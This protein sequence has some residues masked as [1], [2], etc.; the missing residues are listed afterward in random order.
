MYHMHNSTL[1]S[2]LYHLSGSPAAIADATG[3]LQF[4]CPGHAML[5]LIRPRLTK[6]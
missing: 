5:H 4:E 6:S 2:L 3:T 1:S